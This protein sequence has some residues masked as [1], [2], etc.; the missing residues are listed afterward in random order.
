LPLQIDAASNCIANY[1]LS[2]GVGPGSIVGVLL[3]RSPNMVAALLAVLKIGAAFLPLD[4][5]HPESRI[6]RMLCL[7]PARQQLHANGKWHR[8]VHSVMQLIT[9]WQGTGMLCLKPCKAAVTCM[10]KVAHGY[11]QR[12][13]LIM[14]TVWSGAGPAVVVFKQC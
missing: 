1:L 6:A 3:L 13:E 9:P 14:I 2:A 4:H 12:D 8:G 11:A 10:C 7:N 5:H